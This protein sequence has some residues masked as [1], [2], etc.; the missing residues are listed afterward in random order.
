MQY[1]VG[2]CG[3]FC[4]PLTKASVLPPPEEDPISNMLLM[5]DVAAISWIKL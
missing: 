4:I 2:L 5:F 3:L 1:R